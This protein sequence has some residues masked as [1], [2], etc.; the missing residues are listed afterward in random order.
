[1]V[2][3]AAVFALGAV[4]ASFWRYIY[5]RRVFKPG[6]PVL[7]EQIRRLRPDQ[8]VALLGSLPAGSDAALI[9]EAAVS[10]ADPHTRAVLVDEVMLDVDGKL[11]RGQT[12]PKTAARVAMLSGNAFAVLELLS[13]LPS[14]NMQSLLRIAACLIFGTVGAFA[15][16]FCAR[17][18]AKE[19]ERQA[20][21][22]YDVARRLAASAVVTPNP[23]VLDGQRLVSGPQGG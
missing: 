15:A 14:P 10:N 4:L 16:A 22:W 9:V 12:L 7:L 20:D 17:F 5:L 1:M 11:R 13:S 2:W 23:E 21:A 19:R 3:W 6:G 18:A 8:L